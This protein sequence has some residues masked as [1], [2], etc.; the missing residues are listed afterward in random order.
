[1]SDRTATLEL[2]FLMP[3]QAQKHVT[4]ND[5]LSRLDMLVQLVVEGFSET[6]PPA[7]PAE[8]AVYALGAGATAGW[9]GQDNRL[10]AYQN[11]AWAFVTPQSGWR[12]W[13]RQDGT[14]RVWTGTGWQEQ[15]PTLDNIDRIGVGT[16]ADAGNRLAVASPATLLTHEGAGH[17]LKINKAADTD[18]ASL[19]FQTGWSGR[20]EMGLAGTDSFAIKVSADGSAWRTGLSIDGATG[21]V[22]TAELTVTSGLFLGGGT[23]QNR[24]TTYEEGS[25]SPSLIDMSGNSVSLAPKQVSYVRVGNQVSL[26][27][28]F[29]SNLDTTGL[30]PGDDIAVTLPFV[31]GSHSFT[32]VELGGPVATPGPYHWYASLGQNFARIRSLDTHAPLQVSDFTSGVTDIVGGTLV[33]NLG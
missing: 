22:E 7:L 18:T 31:N 28:N 24:L 30:V 3:S 23:A 4:H 33:I 15:V 5:A 27:F 8:G 6:T 25:Y 16:T 10:A 11:G 26:F 12:A 19:L 14:L 9:A 1:M 17:Q 21:G 20:A 2:P 32:S 29:M 13:G